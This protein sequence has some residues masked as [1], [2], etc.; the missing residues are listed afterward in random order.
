MGAEVGQKFGQKRIRPKMRFDLLTNK[1]RSSCSSPSKSSTA[2]YPKGMGI[3]LPAASNQVFLSA[4]D[5]PPLAGVICGPQNLVAPSPS[6]CRSNDTFLLGGV[7]G[8]LLWGREGLA[9]PV[10][11]STHFLFASGPFHQLMAPALILSASPLVIPQST[12]A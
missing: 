4:S 9:M 1:H 6:K 3:Q 7:V 5:W 12:R 10:S 2:L 8:P 11:S